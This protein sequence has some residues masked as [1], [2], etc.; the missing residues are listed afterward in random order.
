MRL[1]PQIGNNMPVIAIDKDWLQSLKLNPSSNAD[2]LVDPKAIFYRPL[3]S[4]PTYE[5]TSD[6]WVKSY[7]ALGKERDG[8]W[9]VPLAGIWDRSWSDLGHPL[10][11]QV[12]PQEAFTA[13]QKTFINSLTT[14]LTF[15]QSPY[16]AI[17]EFAT[18]HVHSNRF[19]A[20]NTGH[21]QRRMRLSQ[22]PSLI[23]LLFTLLS[24][25][26][27]SECRPKIT[28]QL[29]ELLESRYHYLTERDCTPCGWAPQGGTA[30]LCCAAGQTCSTNQLNQAV[31]N[32][33]GGGGTG[34]NIQA[35]QQSPS[36][37]QDA[38]GWEF[39]T[40]TTVG[41]GYVTSTITYSS[42]F[43]AATSAAAQTSCSG[44][45]GETP[46]GGM[47]CATGT[48]CVYAGKCAASNGGGDSSSSVLGQIFTPAATQSAPSRPTS[49][50]ATTV[51]S[52]GSATTTVPFST[53][54][55]ATATA[56][57][58]SD[59]MTS[60]SN[61]GLSPGAIAGIV[62][63]VI[64]AIIFLLL[65]ILCC[66]A[67]AGLDACLTFF[68]LRN[69]RRKT[70]TTVIEEHRHHHGASGGRRRWFGLA[71]ARADTVTVKKKKSGGFWGP[72]AVVGGLTTLAVV[73]GLKRRRDKKTEKSD[74]GAG[75]SYYSDYSYDYSESTK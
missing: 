10:L 34:N 5:I 15:L 64:A 41:T 67:G 68:G 75:S 18:A 60:S 61:N 16:S 57:G 52:T 59:G 29:K 9:T 44:Q 27:I 71:P 58:S 14:T 51:T 50:T 38:A 39:F 8:P 53:A 49:N 56:A 40:T 36:Q 48:Y 63:G 20:I 70:E 25:T 54:T 42:Y 24:T 69:R 17:E 3:Y 28:D 7:A 6:Y 23:S 55:S 37:V 43:G 35:Q 45:M 12:K 66:C 65:L 72:T 31:C 47:C 26:H 2:D 11:D 73:L 33:G 62:I 21:S 4:L 74:Y 46:C 13:Q 30:P 19:A 22:P 1:K 32:D